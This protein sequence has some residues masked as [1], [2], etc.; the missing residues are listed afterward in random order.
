MA[1]TSSGNPYVDETLEE[2]LVI[3]KFDADVD[4]RELIWHRDKEDR[5]VKVLEGKGWILQFEDELP[6]VL[7][8]GETAF[9]PKM[10]YHRLIRGQSDL[11]LKIRKNK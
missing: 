9:I 2:N 10:V 6:A 8:K 5:V 11:I 1:E 4:P 3:R 7:N